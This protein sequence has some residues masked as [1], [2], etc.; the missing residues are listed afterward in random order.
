MDSLSAILEMLQ[1]SVFSPKGI[2]K[3]AQG[4]GEAATLGQYERP[5]HSLKG[6]NNKRLGVFIPFRDGSNGT[7]LFPG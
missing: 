2:H 3:S 5:S 1:R 7:D 6:I 4:C